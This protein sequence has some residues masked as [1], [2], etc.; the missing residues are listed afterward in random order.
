[1]AA[2]R[3]LGWKRVEVLDYTSSGEVTGDRSE[4]VAYAAIG[5][6]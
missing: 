2:A 6:R 1:M 4:V 3:E 5:F